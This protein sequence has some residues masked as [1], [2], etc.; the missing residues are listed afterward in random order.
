MNQ[1]LPCVLLTG[2]DPF[3]GQTINPSWEVV[4]ALHGKR[5]A[6]HRIVARQ[7]PTEF[8]ASLQQLQ[9]AMDELKP[10]LLLGVGQAGGRR[11]LSI[12]RVAININDA[13]I[14]DNAGAR[15]VDEA[16]V[17]DG[18]VAYFSTLPIKAMLAALLA[19]GLPAAISQSAGTYVCN[20]IAYAML[21]LASKRPG[22]RAGFMHIPY[23]P[24]QAAVLGDVPSMAQ[25][26]MER[27][28]RLA[29]HVALTT[30]A[31]LKLAAGS[32]D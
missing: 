16:V 20:H 17:A 4:R 9:K 30:D 15:P 31:D 7:L 13:R 29:L 10:R 6:G 11:Q 14:A 28:V 32:I 24:R 3:G 12:E 18:P 1:K 22:M 8:A 25:A 23:L 26:D 21:H 27:G 19:E 2:F 5:I